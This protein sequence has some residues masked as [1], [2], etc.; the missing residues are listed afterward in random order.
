[1]EWCYV[2]HG[3]GDGAGPGNLIIIKIINNFSKHIYLLLLDD[4]QLPRH[5]RLKWKEM[6]RLADVK[7]QESLLCTTSLL[8]PSIVQQALSGD[9]G[10]IITIIIHISLLIMRIKEVLR[11]LPV[12]KRIVRIFTSSTFT[13]TKLERNM[14]MRDV[15]PF[16]SLICRKLGLSFEVVDMRWVCF[17]L[18]LVLLF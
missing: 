17:F 18:F 8:P 6:L 11:E 13:D 12:R 1:M 9:E 7:L 4:W 5:D 16:L 3:S 15:Y 2:P 10:T 14:L